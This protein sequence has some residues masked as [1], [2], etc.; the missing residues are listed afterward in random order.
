VPQRKK[1]DSVDLKVRMKEPLR[2]RLEAAARAKG[3]S[4]NA[5]AVD[6]LGRSFDREDL[7]PEVLALPF[8]KPLAGILLLLGKMMDTAGR[9]ATFYAAWPDVADARPSSWFNSAYAFGDAVQAAITALERLRPTAGASLAE[10]EG[11]IPRGV[12]AKHAGDRDEIIDGTL[13]DAANG[14]SANRFEGP[15]TAALL[16]ELLGEDLSNRIKQSTPKGRND[17]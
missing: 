8:G 15:I 17:Q 16:H 14:K 10:V 11:R 12:R 9:D 6:R 7:L 1:T 3:V 4:L 2:A 13:R 5:E